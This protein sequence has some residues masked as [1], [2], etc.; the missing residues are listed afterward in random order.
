MTKIQVSWN[1]K[2]VN[3]F[4]IQ[5][6]MAYA[7]I[8]PN[9][10]EQNKCAVSEEHPPGCWLNLKKWA[11]LPVK[12][13][14]PW[15]TGSIAQLSWSAAMHFFPV[16]EAGQGDFRFSGLEWGVL[17]N[18]PKRENSQKQWYRPKARE[19]PMSVGLPSGKKRGQRPPSG[20]QQEIRP[21][22]E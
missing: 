15:D 2:I 10:Q 9:R 18:Q 14:A 13:I 11:V 5:Y 6:V 12:V 3:Y 4:L 7:F 21:F 19:E 17:E 20:A 16:F 1:T 8:T 22:V